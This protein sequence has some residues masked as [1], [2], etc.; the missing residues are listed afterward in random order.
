MT[1]YEI[2]YA[3]WYEFSLKRS[4]Q[5]APSSI[6]EYVERLRPDFDKIYVVACG[7]VILS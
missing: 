6:G 2:G 7:V 5:V 4:S 3:F 1:N